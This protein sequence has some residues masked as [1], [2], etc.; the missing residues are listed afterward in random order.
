M[1]KK[2]ND[3]ILR[4]ENVIL[5]GYLLVSAYIRGFKLKRWKVALFMISKVTMLAA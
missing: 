2:E 5:L 3:I 1:T 4:E